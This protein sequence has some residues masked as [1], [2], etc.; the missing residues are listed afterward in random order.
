MK[1]LS[2]ATVGRRWPHRLLKFSLISGALLAALAVAG[3]YY[4]R[5]KDA[6]FLAFREAGVGINR[7]LK[8]FGQA[9]AD[10]VESHRVDGILDF[11]APDFRSP[12]RG[13]WDLATPT[14]VN[15]ISI[16][17][18]RK[19]NKP[20]I[21]RQAVSDFWQHYIAGLTSVEHFE[22]KINL[23]EEILPGKSARVTVK[24]ILDAT[25]QSKRV[26]QDRFF[27]R[28]WLRSI[29]GSP[30]WKIEREELLED[31]EVSNVRT[32]GQA[33]GFESIE[34][35]SIG[36]D[37]VHQRDPNLDPDRPGVSLKFA[38][39]QHSP[40]G[41]TAVDYDDDGWPDILFTSGKDLRLYRNLGTQPEG[42]CRFEDVTTKAGLSGVD[43]STCALF[44][45]TDNDG[46]KDLF[47]ARYGAPCRLFHNNGDGTFTDR[48]HEMGLDFVQPATAACFLDYDRDGFIDLY[49]AINGDAVHEVPRIPFFARNA[50]PNRLYRNRKGEG[51]EDVTAK[52][53]VGDTGWS[54]AVCAGDFDGDGWPDIAVANDFGRKG[55]Y[56][57]NRDGTFTERAKEAGTLNFSGGMGIAMGD[58]DGDG[59]PEIYASNI[60]SNQRWLGEEKALLQYARN[61]VRSKWL[62]RDFGEFRDL[63]QLTNHDWHS[64]GKS[65]GEGNALFHN[66]GDGTFRQM[67]E[68]CTNRAGWGWGV[69]LFDANNDGKLDIYAANGWITGKKKDD[70]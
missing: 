12:E 55:L 48:S 33:N 41:V 26:I 8:M 54:L 24:Y 44:A 38:V 30:G 7:C 52:A 53:G 15:G 11:Y 64:I 13:S 17:N 69:A 16:A 56:R 14:E 27:F 25:D 31:P 57:N 3:W 5:A 49:V 28:W 61:T 43:R 37:F 62:F 10:A 39:I 63:Y 67:R 1:Q 66:N 23:A 45:D 18:L 6:D 4:L 58:L 9:A 32:A 51:F 40:G 19:T 34:P 68:S 35:T 20:G 47:I 50:L 60:Y 29:P 2:T 46:H 59:L 65:A 36:I 42:Q 70:L 22:C 21:D